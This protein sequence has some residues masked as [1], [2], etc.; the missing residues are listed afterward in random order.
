MKRNVN[1]KFLISVILLI[2][3]TVVFSEEMPVTRIEIDA[4]INKRITKSQAY[5][6]A[7]MVRA[8]GYG[9][10]SIS[11]ASSFAMSEGYRLSCNNYRYTYEIENKGGRWSVKVK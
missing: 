7:G 4:K 2:Q 6:M 3:S 10:S 8:Y 9:C 1:M 5:A 11:S